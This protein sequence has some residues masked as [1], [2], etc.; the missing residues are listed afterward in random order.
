MTSPILSNNQITLTASHFLHR[1]HVVVFVLIVIGSLA[2]ANFFI[3][4]SINEKRLETPPANNELFDIM[5]ISRINSLNKSSE[6]TTQ[7]V[8][9]A[10]RTNPFR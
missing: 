4:Q 5:T 2:A 6:E 1:Y 10:G 8:L 9:P 3:A 7:F